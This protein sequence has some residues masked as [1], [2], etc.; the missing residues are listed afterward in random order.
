MS[1][2][3]LISLLGGVPIILK[4]LLSL[5]YIF[6]VGVYSITDKNTITKIS[7][8]IRH[9][10][11]RNEINEPFGFFVDFSYIGYITEQTVDGSKTL[12]LICNPSRFGLLLNNQKTS[13]NDQIVK[14][15]TRTGN[16]FCIK[17]K[18]TNFICTDF[19]P[20]NN[21]MRILNDMVSHYTQHRKCVGVITGEPGQGKTFLGVL[22]AKTL[23]GS[24]CK[25][26]R[27]TEPGDN[28]RCL[29]DTVK[30]TAETPLVI[31]LDEFDEMLDAIRANTVHGHDNIPIEVRNKMSWNTLFDDISWNMYPFVIVILTSN[32]SKSDID[33]SYIRPGR[34]DLF[35]EL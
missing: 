31:L 34:V 13:K 32:M 4:V 14:L 6:G 11:M 18:P 29:Y 35:Y 17:Y 1:N 10:T 19:T 27:P 15:Y 3:I 22:I 30:P 33:Q 21:Q 28:L 25:T 23:N 26:Y 20:R 2:I 7:K 8:N 5:A 24:L 12:Y 9:S 16:Y